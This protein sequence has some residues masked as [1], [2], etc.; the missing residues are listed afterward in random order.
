MSHHL[1]GTRDGQLQWYQLHRLRP[2]VVKVSPGTGNICVFQVFEA[3]KGRSEERGCD[4]EHKDDRIVGCVQLRNTVRKNRS[5][6]L[7]FLIF[8]WNGATL[9]PVLTL[10]QPE[11]YV[12]WPWPGCWWSCPPSSSWL[13]RPLSPWASHEAWSMTFSSTVATT[14]FFLFC[15]VISHHLPAVRNAQLQ[16]CQLVHLRHEVVK[17][18]PGKAT[19]V[20]FRFLKDRKAGLK[21][22]GMWTPCQQ[23]GRLC[24]A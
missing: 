19:F 23:E 2:E 15:F 12:R 18:S 10:F 16:R 22:V 5:V 13:H 20:C 1:P 14:T 6:V 24:R 9:T 3:Q 21:R 8:S 17:V 4:C 11:H 7:I